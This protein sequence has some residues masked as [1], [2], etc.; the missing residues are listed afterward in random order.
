MQIP[1]KKDSEFQNI[2][3]KSDLFQPT[4]SENIIEKNV[5]VCTCA[6]THMHTHTQTNLWIN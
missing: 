4:L 3:I 6:C 2:H 1:K 5:Y